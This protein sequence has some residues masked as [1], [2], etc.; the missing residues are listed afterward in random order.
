MKC[1]DC[2]QGLVETAI[3]NIDKSYRCENC[4]GF[5]VEP[6]VVNRVAEGQMRDFPAVKTDVSKYQ[7]KSNK[8]PIDGGMLYGDSS[9]SVPPEVVAVKCSH[10]GWWWF[11]ADNLVKFKKAHEAKVSYLKWWKGKREVTMMALPAI[12]VLVLAVGL[13]GGTLVVRQQ[14]GK[15]EAALGASEF[16]AEY[17]G[18]GKVK[19]RFQTDKD[20]NFVSVRPLTGEV[21]GPAEAVK[22]EDGN[23][24]V[25]LVG[26]SEG[27]VFQ[28]QIA[29]KR[30]Y[31]STKL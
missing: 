28:V 15:A 20:I 23:Y 9:D 12:L 18:D 5:W 6:W 29:G 16:R 4:G 19:L 1:P 25:E 22:G 26:L 13:V 2:S 17:L 8:C 3:T 10:C 24:E 31:F 11:G 21:W 27:Q 7:G 14:Q 30:Y